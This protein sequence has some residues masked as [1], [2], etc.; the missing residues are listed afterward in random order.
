M[1]LVPLACED[2]INIIDI[3][4]KATFI[5]STKRCPKFNKKIDNPILI[6]RDDVWLG[7]NRIK[8]KLIAVFQMQAD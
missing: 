4:W 7:A 8:P 6:R 1:D 5:A 2:V 3:V